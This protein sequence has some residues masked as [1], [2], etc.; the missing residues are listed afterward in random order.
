M[1]AGLALADLYWPGLAAESFVSFWES[2]MPRAEM[3]ETEFNAQHGSAEMR[4]TSKLI[5]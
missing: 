5:N 1:L 3:S 2:S 4:K